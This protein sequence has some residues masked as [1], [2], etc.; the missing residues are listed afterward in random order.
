MKRKKR[1]SICLC[2]AFL[3]FTVAAWCAPVSET[4]QT[5]CYDNTVE[6]PCPSPGQPFYG[7][8]GNYI[9]NPISYTKLDSSGNVLTDPAAAWVMIR[10]NVTGLIWGNKTDDG[11]IHD[12][13]NKY[14]WYD[15]NPATN[16]GNAGTP[17]TDTDTEYFLKTLNNALFGGY[18]DWR[19]P[20][21]KDLA[22]IVN[23]SISSPGPTIDSGYFSNAPASY[24]WTSTTS[25]N[26]TNSAWS[27]Y[28]D[29]GFTNYMY[30]SNAYS[31]YAVRAEPSGSSSNSTIGSFAGGLWDDVS[32]A[33][34]S[35]YT[36]NGDGTV[37][38]NSTGL[39]WEQAGS[40]ETLKWERALSYCTTLN[41]G[42][43]TDWRMPT[44][45][46][47]RSL[48]DYSRYYPAID[49]AF[50]PDTETSFYWSS[51]TY[52][53]NPYSAWGVYFYSGN[54]GY[55]NKTK[56]N[57][58]RAVRGGQAGP[59]DQPVLSVSPATRE[60]TQ[61]AGTTPFDVSNT[62]TGTMVWTAVVMSGGDWLSIISGASASNS[63]TI[64]CSYSANAT[65]VSRT[66]IIRITADGATGSPIDVSVTQAPTPT[67][68]TAILDENLTLHIPYLSYVDQ[69]STPSSFWADLLYEYNPT[70]PDLI[71]FKLI[72][73]D[74]IQD[75]STFSCQPSTL[76]SDFKV[77]IPD[78]LLPD[79]ITHIW[80]DM[81]YSTT[82]S[83]DSIV[84]F[85]ITN[86]GDAAI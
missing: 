59:M 67:A 44:I 17:G 50:F 77:H 33:S 19:L 35:S 49:T 46:E 32:T 36:D 43:Y 56:Y 68:C 1:L 12:K 13:D 76:S 84:Y 39:M 71:F 20:T 61:D 52:A 23:Y 85:F 45:K 18:S 24:H 26:Y 38:D 34:G 25:A 5:K 82:L 69:M 72:K 53:N 41:I 66:G 55:I 6:I 75:T 40:P 86:Y 28:F 54:D 27:T 42:N 11:S 64:T 16:G 79:G 57:Y 21:V 70:Y 8:D 63:G 48:V 37:T 47:L 81:E 80:V 65:A 2:A 83:T 74:V 9:I 7:Q 22:Y 62:G 29:Y 15:S 30:K 4:G 14:T 51:T 58:V 10:D 73:A 3:F 78:V 60:V 31:A